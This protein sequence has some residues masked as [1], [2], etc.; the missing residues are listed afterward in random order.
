LGLEAIR[1]EITLSDAIDP[2]SQQAVKEETDYVR[3]RQKLEL[4]DYQQDIESRKQYAKHLFYLI[5]VW[6][7]AIFALLVL[8]GFKGWSF[9][10]G[11]TPIVASF[12]L[13]DT[14]LLALIGSTTT[15]VIGLFGVVVNYLFP[16]RKQN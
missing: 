6:L 14:V 15:T 2:E 12:S 11:K 13:S 4:R 5:C 16:Q 7:V 8:S 9:N 3:E 1:A 10:F